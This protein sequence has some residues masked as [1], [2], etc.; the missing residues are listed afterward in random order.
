MT[1]LDSYVDWI[2]LGFPL[3]DL[4]FMF[5]TD[6]T[7]LLL[8]VLEADKYGSLLL[9]SDTCTSLQLVVGELKFVNAPW[10]RV[11]SSSTIVALRHNMIKLWFF[12][13]FCQTGEVV[14]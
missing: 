7:V 1:K 13:L 5:L 14:G 2:V 6:F 3:I 9:Q 10:N 8:Q 12:S 4:D 11:S